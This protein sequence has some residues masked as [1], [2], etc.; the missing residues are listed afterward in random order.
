MMDRDSVG[1]RVPK[2]YGEK[3]IVL[4][5]SLKITDREL[6]IQ[7]DEKFIYIP[8]S[9]EPS[10]TEIGSLKKQ[11]PEL[12]VSKYT[13]HE[14]KRQARTVAEL[15]ENQLAPHLL[16]SLPHAIDFVGDIAIIELSQEL[17]PHKTAVGEAILKTHKNVHTVLAKAGAVGGTYRLREFKLIAGE[18]KTETIHKEY[19]CKYHVDVAKAYFSPRLSTEHKR[20]ASLVK[21]GE[22][23]V[24]MFAGVGPFAIQIA[25]AK[26]KV[27][28]YAVDVNPY[29]VELL[30]ENIRLNKVNSKVHSFLGDS[31]QIVR[32]RLRGVADRAIMNLPEKAFEYVDVACE[33]LKPEGGIVHFYNFVNASET[34][35]NMKLRF[36]DA[37]KSSG[38]EVKQILLSRFV[39]ET[40]PYE[41][42]M[43]LDAEIR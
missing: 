24:D 26:E 7:K 34:V 28:V 41:W 35:D 11:I 4:A 30:K 40:A 38:R 9:R 16:A 37:V 27:Q 12:K 32:E 22:T 21:D 10:K 2:I 29:A 6:E 19:G 36:A 8:L 33:A 39:R 18:P 3:A 43:V 42:Q 17:E 13:F 25:K 15:L 5:N 31:R 20:V 1:V 14:K 23:V